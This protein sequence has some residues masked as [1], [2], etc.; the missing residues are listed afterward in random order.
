MYPFDE[1]V[2]KIVANLRKMAAE[3]ILLHEGIA[4]QIKD[5]IYKLK[6]T[7]DQFKSARD[8]VQ[9]ATENRELN[10]R[11]YQSEL[12]ETKDVIEAQ[13]MESI[14]QAQFQ[15]VLYDHVDTRARLNFVVGSEVN[16]FIEAKKSD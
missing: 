7:Q 5:V 1:G 11:A 4:L 10:E 2:P 9:A 8:A 12:V 13:I 14:L 16:K 6:Q 15:K 3:K